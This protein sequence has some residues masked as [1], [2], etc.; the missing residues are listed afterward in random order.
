M[1]VHERGAICDKTSEMLGIAEQVEPHHKEASK[2]RVAKDEKGCT[3]P[4]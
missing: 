4:M 2:Q 1:T 3:T